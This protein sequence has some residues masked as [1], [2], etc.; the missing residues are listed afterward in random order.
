MDCY[1][2]KRERI[3]LIGL[4]LTLL[5][6]FCFAK[7]LEPGFRTWKQKMTLSNG[8]K[9]SVYVNVKSIS[10]YDSDGKILHSRIRDL[11]GVSAEWYKY[12]SNGN[13]IWHGRSYGYEEWKD[14][15]SLN[16]N[17]HGKDS[18]G[19]EWENKFDSQGKLVLCRYL[20]N[21]GHE[22]QYFYNSHG[23]LIREYEQCPSLKIAG[24]IVSYR[25]IITDYEYDTEGNRISSIKR[26]GSLRESFTHERFWEYD[27]KGHEIAYYY[28][29]N[30][31]KKREIPSET[32]EYEFWP[33]GNI[34]TKIAYNYEFSDTFAEWPKKRS[35]ILDKVHP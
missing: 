16:Q 23:K 19:N 10:E 15:N 26:H 34:K 5:C 8:K 25:D 13:E 9:C 29:G 17:I 1:A 33:N 35:S 7:D 22:I 11:F 32:Y 24:E 14:Y 28:V 2:K 18:N 30:G 21:I 3:T 31:A 4:V 6:T 20:S 12:D 27:A